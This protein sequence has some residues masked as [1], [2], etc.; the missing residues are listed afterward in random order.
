MLKSF[1]VFLVLWKIDM[2]FES[3]KILYLFRRERR[4]K[5][6]GERVEKMCINIIL[7]ICRSVN[8]FCVPGFLIFRRGF[9]HPTTPAITPAFIIL[10][11]S[12]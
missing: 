10:P 2:L 7:I 12:I 4:K 8:L 9:K 5:F 1:I 6:R 3:P 11:I